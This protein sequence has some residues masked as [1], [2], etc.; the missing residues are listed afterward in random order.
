MF[1][2]TMVRVLSIGAADGIGVKPLIAPWRMRA[3]VAVPVYVA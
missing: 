2:V 3:G 1:V